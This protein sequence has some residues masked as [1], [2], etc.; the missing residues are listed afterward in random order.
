MVLKDMI[1]GVCITLAIILVL[2][3]STLPA[4]MDAKI[5][6]L[7]TLIEFRNKYP[8]IALEEIRDA[9]ESGSISKWEYDNIRGVYYDYEK[10]LLMVQLGD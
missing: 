3:I 10:A 4:R 7:S 2:W 9:K 6:Q 8:N 5:G 1:P